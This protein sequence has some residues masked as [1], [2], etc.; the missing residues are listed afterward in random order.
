MTARSA[1]PVLAAAAAAALLAGCTSTAPVGQQGRGPELVR[2]GALLTCT[3]LPY[4]PFQVK[5]DGKVVGFDVDLVD[6]VAKDLHVTQQIINT[7][8]EGIET[9][10]DF[11]IR[12]CDLAAAGMTITPARTKVMDFSD[13]YFNATQALLVKHGTSVK[14]IEDLKGKK[15]GY[16]KATTGALYAK[17][18]GKGVE[19][20]E[21]EDVGLLLTAVGS[22]QVDAGINDN[23]VLL[24]YA[25]HNP[26]THVA[27]EFD[28]GEHYGFGVRQGND[29]LRKR[30]NEVLA[31]AKKDGSYNRIHRKWFG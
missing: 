17:A 23:G 2:P 30:I 9:G 31:R 7:P 8:F 4:A 18:H 11:A 19:L 16:Q 5:R 14:K 1:L 26:D 13:P 28:T 6:L 27:E 10:Q 24:D 3:H 20:V 12:T 22:G 15:L 29:A 21:F 25:K